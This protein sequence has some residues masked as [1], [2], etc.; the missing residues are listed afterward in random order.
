MEEH[1]TVDQNF[2]DFE[3]HQTYGSL[4]NMKDFCVYGEH[5][6]IFKYVEACF[7]RW[8]TGFFVCDKKW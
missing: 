2:H 5:K 1:V 3:L 6:S 8:L 4:K 7:L